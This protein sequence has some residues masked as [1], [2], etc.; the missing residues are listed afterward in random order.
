MLKLTFMKK[1]KAGLF[2]LFSSM[3]CCTVTYSQAQKTTIT[4]T[5]KNEKGEVLVGATLKEIG[6]KTVVLTDSLGQFHMVITDPKHEIE[7]SHIGY[8]NKIL[9]SDNVDNIILTEHK[10]PLDDVVVVGYSTQSRKKVTAAVSSLKGDVIKDIPEATFDQMLQGRLAG[11]SVMSPTGEPGAKANI[12]IR[13][14]TNMDYGNANGGNA[15]PLYVID[16]QI[17]DINNMGTAYG[18][19]NPLSIIDPNSIESIDVLKDASAAAIY[20]ARGGNGVIIVKTKRSKNGIRSQVT[21]SLYTGVTTRPNL[22]NVRLGS[23]ERDLK[24]QYLSNQLPYIDIQNGL[25]PQALTDSLNPVFNGN[26]DWQKLVMRSNAIV[27]SQEVALSGTFGG[28]NNY[29]LS[30][31]HYNEQG[32]S[33]GYNL[34]KLAPSFSLTIHPIRKVSIAT[35]L[36]MTTEKQKHG[37]NLYGSPFLWPTMN[38]FPTSLINLTPAQTSLYDGSAE[39]YDDNSRFSINGN[40]H[41]TDTILKNVVFHSVIGANNFNEKYDY[42]SPV[43][44]NGNQNRAFHNLTDNPN[45]SW[46]N[47][48]EYNKSFGDHNFNFVGGYSNYKA[49]RFQDYAY[50]YGINVSGIYSLQTIPSGPNLYVSTERDIKTTSSYYGRFTYDYRGKYL[51]TGSVRRDASSI[52]SPDYRWGTFAAGSLGWV[53][54]DET[55]WQPLKKVV[56]FFKLRVSYG[57]TGQDPGS[58]YGKYQQLYTDASYWN[59]TT[60]VIGGDAYY[61]NL[62]GIPSTYNGT[63]VV[64]PYN[65]NSTFVN[66]AIKSSNSVR[67]EKYPQLDIGADVNFFNDRINLVVDW[68]QKDA[69][70]KYLWQIPAAPTSGYAY[71]SGNY[72]DIRNQGLEISI[73]TRNLG[74]N[75]PVTWSTNFNV[76]FNKN[77]I[78]KLPNGNQDMLFG[79]PWF[80]KTFTLG[81]P[82]FAYK[83]FKTNG[84]YATNADVPVDPI[85]GNKMTIWGSSPLQAGDARIEDLNGDYNIDYNDQFV[86]NSSPLP[87]VTGGMSNTFSYKG[88]SLTVFASFSYG[89]KVLNGGLSD[90]LNGS[91][92]YNASW[93]SNASIAAIKDLS[94]FWAQDGDQT[95]YPRLVYA[96]GTAVNDPWNISRGY[97]LENGGFVKIK[98]LTLG[99]NLPSNFISK[100]GFK[101]LNVFGMAENLHT[102]KQA[103]DIPDPELYD[104]TTGSVNSVYPT[105]LKFTFG[106]N[107]TL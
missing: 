25:F 22:Q 77:Y 23:A 8:A 29:R 73:S 69:K 64:V 100:I 20:G 42:F 24:L 71:Y 12:V 32:F 47:Y 52:Y 4:G 86:D 94:Q 58:W 48:L 99:Y 106:L 5:V 104:P 57:V 35:T 75:S 54:S 50:A 41:L 27:N 36:M 43:E 7:I 82:L 102:F 101:S 63:T 13:G 59:S 89:N 51:V 96:N 87:K 1:K 17:F 39:R 90:L 34:Q 2:W 6:T 78:T 83:Y 85:T 93:G 67:W 21:A 30:L 38:N 65:Y 80:R 45:W 88:F 79:D 33:K 91:S 55:F 62:Q 53:A 49:T 31:N 76:A 10:S 11:V 68:Y 92:A 95:T 46:E 60:G 15:Q 40:V 19:S 103:K 97:F 107:L 37:P 105:S 70:D 81:S 16:G 84:V 28:N 98:Q 66:N 3:L 44:L 56:N 74:N 9:A 14:S 26:T 18:N 72:A 61:Q